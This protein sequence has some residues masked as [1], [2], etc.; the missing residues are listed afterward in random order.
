[1]TWVLVA[2]WAALGSISFAMI[3]GAVDEVRRAPSNVR[4]TGLGLA[5]VASFASLWMLITPLSSSA[6]ADCGAPLLVIAELTGTVSNHDLACAE[7]L[8]ASVAAGM[9]CALAAPVV[10]LA[11]RGRQE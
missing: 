2:L 6:G 9:I 1:M 10:V 7:P 8:R 3:I 4:R 5:F 11:T